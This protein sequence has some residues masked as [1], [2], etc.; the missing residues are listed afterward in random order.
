VLLAVFIAIL[1]VLSPLFGRAAGAQSAGTPSEW[2]TLGTMGG[3][4]PSPN[5]SQ[6][7]DLLVSGD[8][9]IL[10]DA[11]DGAAEQLAKA[12]VALARI[13]TIFISHLHFD[14]M[15]GL[16]AVLG[17]RF[18]ISSP[19]TVTIYGPPGTKR[20]VDGLIAAMQPFAEVGAGIPGQIPRQPE[21]GIA[22]VEI[23]GGQSVMVGSVK[24]T[25]TTNTHYSFPVGSPEAARFQ[26]LSLRFDLPDRSIVYT[27]DTGPSTNVE[28]LA[29]GADLLVSEVV[30]IDAAVA[31]MK[32]VNPTLP[33]AALAM[34][35]QHLTEQHLTPDQVAALAHDA[36]VKKVVLVHNDLSADGA[37]AAEAVIAR[38]YSGPVVAAH[39]LDRF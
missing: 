28:R 13:H 11:G 36:G 25:A 12:G 3:A 30:D 39:D 32:L 18:Q 24:V 9:A 34:F 7:A 20:M 26:S 22:V 37:R 33:P 17:L 4:I 27:G 2:I 19:G 1:L 38:T 23:T 35:R 16:F 31:S 10:I 29:R 15:G 5:R 6:P 14:H 8:Q 21:Q